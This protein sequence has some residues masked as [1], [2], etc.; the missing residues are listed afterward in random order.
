MHVPKVIKA[1]QL[2]IVAI[3]AELASAQ[4]VDRRTRS[5]RWPYG[6]ISEDDEE[7]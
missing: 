3:E 5:G 1:K 4:D 6:D 2:C 7:D